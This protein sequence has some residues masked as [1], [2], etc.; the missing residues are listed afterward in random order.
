MFSSS[1]RKASR[2]LMQGGRRLAHALQR[3]RGT[4]SL[5]RMAQAG[6]AES[7]AAD[8]VPYSPPAHVAPPVASPASLGDEFWRKV[9]V[10]EHVDASEFLSYRWSV[11]LRY[12]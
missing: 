12:P 8:D 3:R 2:I 10:W 11:S 7:L 1:A 6:L 5:P 9:P 4:A